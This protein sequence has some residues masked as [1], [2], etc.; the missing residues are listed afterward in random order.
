MENPAPFD[1]N[2]AIRR[3]QKNLAASP[4]F[5]ADNIE[6]LA[7]H[8]RDSVRKLQATGLCEEE[9]FLTATRRIGERDTLEREFGKVNPGV[10]RSLPVVLFWIV[11]GIYLFQ[12][13]YSLII[14]I[15]TWRARHELRE[16]AR[17]FSEAVSVGLIRGDAL[18]WHL[19]F[20]RPDPRALSIAA[21]LV[22]ILGARLAVGS[23]KGV[24]ASIRSF[25]P[26]I[27]AMTGLVVLGLVVIFLPAFFTN[28]RM[29][30]GSI[31]LQNTKWPMETYDEVNVV[32]VFTMVLLA[33]RGSS[34]IS[35]ADHRKAKGQG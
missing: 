10:T 7:S 20:Y 27:W 12:I 26:A 6:E 34:K 21:I 1:L 11:A 15:L 18:D 13:V 31:F 29:G 4:A 35:L 3:W 16:Y 32:L 28:Y 25:E 30:W 9:A 19:D 14:L 24:G 8:L 22:F 33:R 2:E 5:C 17:L 23:W